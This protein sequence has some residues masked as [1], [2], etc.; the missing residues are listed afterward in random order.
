MY[1]IE[2]LQHTAD[3]KYKIEAG[4][5][6]DLFRGSLCAMGNLIKENTCDEINN[7]DYKQHVKLRSRDITSLLINFLSELLTLTHTE[8]II[9]CQVD[10]KLLNNNEL[11]CVV[12]GK[13]VTGF[14]EDVKAVTYHEADVM[15]NSEGYWQ[16]NLVMDI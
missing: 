13:S 16:T 3:V 6:E 9:F 14:D 2:A 4:S 7:S 8:R 15:R 5:L 12:S 11:E 10:F 1:R